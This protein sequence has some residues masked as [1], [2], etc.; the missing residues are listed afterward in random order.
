MRYDSKYDYP[1]IDEI[2]EDVEITQFLR[3]VGKKEAY[4]KYQDFV[5]ECGDWIA[6]AYE[7]YKYVVYELDR[8]VYSAI[9]YLPE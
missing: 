5:R 4:E 3:D 1:S 7:D 9:S 6:L 8:E 2:R